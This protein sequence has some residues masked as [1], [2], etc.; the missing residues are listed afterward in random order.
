MWE[1]GAQGGEEGEGRHSYQY[2][3]CWVLRAV[4]RPRGICDNSGYSG[5]GC[6]I[7]E[8]DRG[9]KVH[10]YVNGVLG[11]GFKAFVVN[12]LFMGV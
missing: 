2:E 12:Y 1:F 8:R 4:M 6:E 7:R 5:R 9:R 11:I 3:R 10:R